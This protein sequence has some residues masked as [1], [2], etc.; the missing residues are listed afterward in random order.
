MLLTGETPAERLDIARREA[1]ILL[2]NGV[3][4]L[5]E[6]YFEDDVRHVLE[7]L[8]ARKPNAHDVLRDH[9][10]AFE[11]A[12][13]FRVDFIQM[14]SGRRPSQ[15]DEDADFAAELAAQ[16]DVPAAGAA[17]VKYS[18][19]QFR[20]QRSGS[21]LL[22]MQRCDAFVVTSD[23]APGDRPSTRSGVSRVARGHFP[24]LIGAGLTSANA[25]EQLAL[26]DG[27]IV[28]SFFKDSYVDT[29]IVDE[30]QCAR[31]DGRRRRYPPPA[32]VR[33]GAGK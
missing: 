32:A 12:R 8:E 5:V 2:A 7:W 15:P 18:A 23:A 20:P 3:D 27:A 19:G 31:I 30:A 29:G 9:H 13:Q 28:G 16:R 4:G 21:L 24:L 33:A 17:C 22:G 25:P 14:D 6:N 10:L 26:A 11:L 1:E